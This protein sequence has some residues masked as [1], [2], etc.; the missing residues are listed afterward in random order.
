M[1]ASKQRSQIRWSNDVPF[2][3]LD[4]KEA[5]EARFDA[6]RRL[7]DPTD[8]L[9]RHGVMCAMM[10]IVEATASRLPELWADRPLN[11]QRFLT[12]SGKIYN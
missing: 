5:F 2:S 9:D 4:D 1:A 7:L 6:V 3:T 10:D 11:V 12:N 8:R